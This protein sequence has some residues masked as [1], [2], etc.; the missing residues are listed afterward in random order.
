MKFEVIEVTFKGPITSLGSSAWYGPAQ[1]GG[2]ISAE[3]DTETQLVTLEPGPKP[4]LKR[5]RVHIS[6]T[7]DMVFGA[8]KAKVAEPLPAAKAPLKP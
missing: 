4:G 2:Y 5:R 7:A 3:Y 8:T 1:S 6:N